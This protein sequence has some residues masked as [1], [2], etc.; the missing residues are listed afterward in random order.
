MPGKVQGKGISDAVRS[1]VREWMTDE[2]INTLSKEYSK[3]NPTQLPEAF[4]ARVR[5]SEDWVRIT[6]HGGTKGWIRTYY[7]KRF[8]KKN[9][10]LE[11]KTNSEDTIINYVT[12]K[13]DQKVVSGGKIRV[14][15]LL[16]S[17]AGRKA[18]IET[19]PKAEFVPFT[20]EDLTKIQSSTKNSDEAIELLFEE[21]YF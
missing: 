1:S 20:K 11:V 13:V 17:Q 9:V 14:P 8:P 6:R 19:E 7:N 2:T 12:V 10:T 4:K 3:G 21:R 18:K 5:S 16:V 15:S